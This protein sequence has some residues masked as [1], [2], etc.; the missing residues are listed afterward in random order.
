MQLD[1]FS[2]AGVQFGGDADLVDAL[3]R[4]VADGFPGCRLPGSPNVR[5]FWNGRLRSTVGRA[6]RD[7]DDPKIEV[8]RSYNAAY[9]DEL[10]ETLAHE[11]AHLLH[12]FDGHGKL[13]RAELEGALVRLGVPLRPGLVHARHLPNTGRYEWVCR[14]CGAKVGS[15]GRRRRD[16]V[17][18]RTR[19]CGAPIGVIDTLMGAAAPPRPFFVQCAICESSFVAY[20]ESSAAL[21]FARRHRCRCGGKLRILRVSG[22]YGVERAG[23]A[24][25]AEP[26]G[27]QRRSKVRAGRRL[28]RD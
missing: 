6:S 12:P 9:P 19:C 13:W 28:P 2:H 10:V 14:R 22:G 3:S 21:R 7:P 17:A 26:A 23:H 11:F 1:L 16:E 5:V 18:M 4:V 20:D 27:A 24:P 25:D 15:T 8:S